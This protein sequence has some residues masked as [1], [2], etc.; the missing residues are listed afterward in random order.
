MCRLKGDG[1]KGGSLLHCRR[2]LA[3]GKGEREGNW[4]WRASDNS[5]RLKRSCSQGRTPKPTYPLE[6]SYRGQRWLT[7]SVPNPWLGASSP[8]KAGLGVN[9]GTR[10]KRWQ[11]EAIEQQCFL[12][13]ILL[14]YSLS[15]VASQLPD[16]ASLLGL[17]YRMR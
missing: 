10:S 3:R 15:S 14:K 16:C 5:Q 1:A 17:L 8:G 4:V 11:L 13:L 12:Q 6:D 7:S 2:G 9:T